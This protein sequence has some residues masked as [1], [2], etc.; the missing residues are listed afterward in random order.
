M[1]YDTAMICRKCGSVQYVEFDRD[2]SYRCPD[3]H[4]D[5]LMA[6]AA[7]DCCGFALICDRFTN[8]CP[9]CGK[10]YNFAGHELAPVEEWDP[11]DRYACFG[12]QNGDDEW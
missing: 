7:V 5:D 6:V 12:P 3:C 9:I 10:L 2:A 11:E 1:K 8:E 4:G